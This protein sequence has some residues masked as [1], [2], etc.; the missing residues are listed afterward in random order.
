MEKHNRSS[1]I[2]VCVLL[3]YSEESSLIHWSDKAILFT[4]HFW[5]II[6]KWKQSCIDFHYVP[7]LCPGWYLDNHLNIFVFAGNPKDRA[8]ML[9]REFSNAKSKIEQLESLVRS[10][11]TD[12]EK[13]QSTVREQQRTLAEKEEQLNEIMGELG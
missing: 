6:Y 3:I 2:H 8:A 10:L 9:E 13:L 7:T 5:V 4:N 1:G 12:K 11:E